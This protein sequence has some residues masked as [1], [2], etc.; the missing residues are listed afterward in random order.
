M[1]D[2][3][4]AP[5]SSSE[6]IAASLG[7]SVE[8]AL[9]M[10]LIG[11]SCE[12]SLE[13]PNAKRGK[14]NDAEDEPGTTGRNDADMHPVENGPEMIIKDKERDEAE[15]A[16]K[17][18]AA[19]KAAKAAITYTPRA[20]AEKAA[21]A[22]QKHERLAEEKVEAE[23]AAIERAEAARLAEEKAEAE[24][25][26]AAKLSM[27]KAAAARSAATD[28]VAAD[29]AEADKVAS[30]KTM[31]KSSEKEMDKAAGASSSAAPAP[32]AAQAEAGDVEMSEMESVAEGSDESLVDAINAVVVFKEADG[33]VKVIAAQATDVSYLVSDDVFWPLLRRLAAETAALQT[34]STCIDDSSWAS[35][36]ASSEDSVCYAESR[37]YHLPGGLAG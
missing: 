11:S 1:S 29:K 30:D 9:A 24:K 15:K 17:K 14:T 22:K 25:V 26:A 2:A 33:S 34:G 12:A 36:P 32:K 5:P 21:A 4:G 13:E 7:L 6:D 23:K 35:A 10:G 27:Q 20:E 19:D 31:Q 8:E 16:A 18:A 37:G 28:K 3:E